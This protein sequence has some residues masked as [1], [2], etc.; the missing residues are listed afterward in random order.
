MGLGQQEQLQWGAGETWPRGNNIGRRP[1][2]R[3]SSG[4]QDSTVAEEVV[5]PPG[6][7]GCWEKNDTSC[8][9]DG[10]HSYVDDIC[11]LET[12]IKRAQFH[13]SGR[14]QSALQRSQA[15]RNVH[16]KITL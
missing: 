3:G 15:Y 4:A 9:G 1:L 2:Q 11:D 8:L 13:L 16:A 10:G 7:R 12:G 14:N 6:E 5:A